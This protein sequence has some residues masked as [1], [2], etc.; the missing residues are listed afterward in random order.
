MSRLSRSCCLDTDS[1]S[2]AD[3]R[4]TVV[5]ASV[6]GDVPSGGDLVVVR[7][8]CELR[9]LGVPVTLVTSG[10]ALESDGF[11]ELPRQELRILTIADRRETS[12]SPAITYL[13][14]CMA[15]LGDRELRSLRD[16]ASV[17]VTSSPFLPDLIVSRLLGPA[18]RWVVSW[19]LEVPRPG[20]R[21]RSLHPRAGLLQ[22][23]KATFSYLSQELTMLLALREKAFVLV[24]SRDL[25]ARAVA[26]GFEESRVVYSRPSLAARRL[27]SALPWQERPRTF[28]FIGRFHAQKGLDDLLEAWDIIASRNHDANLTVVGGG[29]DASVQA[30]ERELVR[31]AP[32]VTY[33]GV[34]VALEKWQV[35]ED[36][37]VLLFPSTY[38]SFGIV[39]DEALAAGCKVVGYD[40]ASTREAFGD[41]VTYVPVSQPERLAIAA[42]QAVEGPPPSFGASTRNEEDDLRQEG[43]LS[44][45]Q[46]L[47]S[48]L[49]I[50][51]PCGK[52]RG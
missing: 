25:A 29:S 30:F 26:R 43:A 12:G 32:R 34:Q 13:G 6:V 23:A 24:P 10:S 31:R 41:R 49:D 38:E 2:R 51:T 14:R 19:Q 5:L 11:A 18:R 28:A 27:T 21:Y 35:L 8:I 33:L 15:V 45:A 42:L 50:R 36:T 47:L 17:T 3:V 22:Q 48:A 7:L 1:Y 46:R 52:S 9:Q 16:S 44:L 37:K 39:V 20:R 40:I 4:V